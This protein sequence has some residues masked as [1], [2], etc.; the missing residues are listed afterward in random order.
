[1]TLHMLDV[2][3]HPFGRGE[4]LKKQ[5]RSFLVLFFLGGVVN[6]LTMYLLLEFG[7]IGLQAFCLCSEKRL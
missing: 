1:M 3:S 2:T 6:A 5:I 4:Y 7:E